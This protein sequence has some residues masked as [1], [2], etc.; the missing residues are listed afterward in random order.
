LYGRVKLR[1][2]RRI[3]GVREFIGANEIYFR[4]RPIDRYKKALT[5]GLDASIEGMVPTAGVELATY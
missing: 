2:R 3:C 4:I 5:E 1:I